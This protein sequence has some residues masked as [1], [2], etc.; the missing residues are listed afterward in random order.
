MSINFYP[1]I[2]ISWRDWFFLN[3]SNGYD[4]YNISNGLG[5]HLIQTKNLNFGASLNYYES[6]DEDD[7]GELKGF[8]D[9]EPGA[10]FQLFSEY[11]LYILSW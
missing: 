4:F 2:D 10:E 8:G 3:I 7:S 1:H 11:L 6:R 5:V 9:I